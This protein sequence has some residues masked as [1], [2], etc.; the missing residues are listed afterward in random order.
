MLNLGTPLAYND[1]TPLFKVISAA[2]SPD[3]EIVAAGTGGRKIRVLQYAFI[4]N[5]TVTVRF[6]GGAGGTALTGQMDFVAQGGM[7]P[8]FSPAG[9]FETAADTNLNLELSATEEV[10]GWIVYQ[11]IEPTS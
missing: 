1:S 9:Y 3:N 5:G 6:E 8:P 7:A 4:A 2:S 10:A 11:L